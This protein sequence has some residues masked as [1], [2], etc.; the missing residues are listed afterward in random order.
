MLLLKNTGENRLTFQTGF[1]YT[2]KEL[3]TIKKY[4]FAISRSKSMD[5][6][7]SSFAEKKPYLIND[8]NSE[9]ENLSPLSIRFVRELGALSFICCPIVC[10][11]EPIGI[12]AVDNVKTKRPLIQSDLRLMMGIASVI[13]IGIKNTE[14]Y[15]AMSQQM[16]SIL[17]VLAASIDARDPYTAGHSEDR[18]S[19]V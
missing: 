13:G 11:R 12:L 17:Q 15:G 1:G 14:L 4:E 2:R 16:K 19:V 8:I 5:I 9:D 3:Q 10:N 7:T 18:K 6:F